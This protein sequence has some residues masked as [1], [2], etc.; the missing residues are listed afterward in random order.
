MNAL[1]FL[2]LFFVCSA[3]LPMAPCCADSTSEHQV[4][5]CITK[6]RGSEYRATPCDSP[7]NTSSV[8]HYKTPAAYGKLAAAV[9]VHD[10]KK[11]GVRPK[12]QKDTSPV[13]PSFTTGD[14]VI[15]G[16]DVDRILRQ[17]KVRPDPSV[18]STPSP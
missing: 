18:T 14:V 6:N 2:S 1:N 16:P 15:T 7:T 5:H 17:L 12:G 4:Y 11:T 13:V 8:S 3:L 9:P 10:Q